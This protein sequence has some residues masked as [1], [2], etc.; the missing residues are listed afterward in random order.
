MTPAGPAFSPYPARGPVFTTAARVVRSTDVTPAGRLRFDAL[1]RY[2]Q[3]AAEDDPKP[4]AP[5]RQGSM[6]GWSAGSPS[7]FAAT[8][9]IGSE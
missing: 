5:R 7:P 8:R 9:S 2:L 3:E 4:A 6:P 1:A